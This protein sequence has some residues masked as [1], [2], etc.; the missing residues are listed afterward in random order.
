[1]SDPTKIASVENGYAV[2]TPTRIERFWRKLGFRYHLGNEPEGI[3]SLE[4]W[5]QTRTWMHFS[6]RDRLRLLLSGRLHIVLTQHL[7]VKCD[8]SKNRLDWMIV[9]PGGRHE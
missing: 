8:F 5:M 4:G 2:Y 9:A 7:P 3:D 6:L 1:M